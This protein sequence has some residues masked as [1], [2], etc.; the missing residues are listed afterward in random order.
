MK[1]VIVKTKELLLRHYAKYKKAKQERLETSKFKKR[2]K[3]INGGYQGTK[4]EYKE[5]VLSYW[6]KYG[7]KPDRMWYALYCNGKDHFDPRFVPESIWVST[8]RP[9]FNDM[10]MRRAYV[11]KGMLNRLLTDVKKPETVAKNIAGYYYDGDGERLISREEAE[12]ICLREDQLIFKPSLDS[13]GGSGI[14][15]YDRARASQDIH[16]LF[17]RFGTNFVVQRI[18]HQHPD[19]SKLNDSSLNTVRV[20]SF[21][22]H[23]QIHI[24]S[25]QLRIGG[26]GAHVDNIGSGGC[27]CPVNP[28]GSLT[29]RGVTRQSAWMDESP[30]G[31]KL[32]TVTV[33]HYQ[34]L[35]QTI[36]RLHPNLPYFDLIG[37]DFAIDKQGDP[38]LIEFNVKPG[39]NQIGSGEPT[40]GDLSDEVFDEVFLKQSKR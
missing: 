2:L 7:I 21:H 16:A 22:F 31:V 30:S 18:V 23:D 13:Y 38:V 4:K 33:P 1:R 26:K 10:S 17:D 40:F 32:S 35:I 14:V 34:N 25:A 15:F 20:L 9:Y 6:S 5:A 8:I 28:D 29:G 3:L 12:M 11:D 37:W 36:K 24:L 27:A 19:L 39:Q